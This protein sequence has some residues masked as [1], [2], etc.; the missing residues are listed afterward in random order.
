M[1]KPTK[2]ELKIEAYSNLKDAIKENNDGQIIVSYSSINNDLPAVA[3]WDHSRSIKPDYNYLF[4]TEEERTDFIKERKDYYN[5]EYSARKAKEAEAN[6]ES[7]KIQAGTIFVETWGYEQTN[8]NFYLVLE[9]K[10]DYLK[11]QEIGSHATYDHQS[12]TGHK[13]PNVNEKLGEVMRKKINKKYCN[14][15]IRDYGWTEIWDGT[16]QS[17]S[18]YA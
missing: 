17:Y 15:K 6:K 3:I 8:V 10:N 4:N 9:R 13:M 14:I 11:I 12:M 18:C 1:R 7:E 2:R 16:K 5:K